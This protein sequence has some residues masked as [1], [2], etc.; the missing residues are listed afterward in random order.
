[1][2]REGGKRKHSF[3]FPAGRSCSRWSPSPHGC[4]ANLDWQ[5]HA[6]GRRCPMR[7]LFKGWRRKFGVVTLVVACVFT[8]G[9]VR[10]L[11]NGNSLFLLALG[12]RHIVA[13]ERGAL[14]WTTTWAT[15]GSK[16]QD[17]QRINWNS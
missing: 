6:R 2:E 4:C 5:P 7:E 16:L 14:W 1:M 8:A 10:S 3:S 12:K 17:F 9:W 13:S 11:T 15:D